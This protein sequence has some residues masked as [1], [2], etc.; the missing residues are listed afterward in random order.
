M[1]NKWYKH[2]G[3]A[4]LTSHRKDMPAPAACDAAFGIWQSRGK[5]VYH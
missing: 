2:M 3:N 5:A 4:A 1:I